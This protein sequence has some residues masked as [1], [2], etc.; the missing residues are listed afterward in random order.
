[1]KKKFLSL[2][3]VLVLCV[4][5]AISASAV[6]HPG[7]TVTRTSQLDAYLP[8]GTVTTYT[9]N[10]TVD[11][12]SDYSEDI[13]ITKE[14]LHMSFNFN[15]G[16][17]IDT[18]KS[19]ETIICPMIDLEESI[20]FEHI[21]YDGEIFDGLSLSV[22]MLENGNSWDVIYKLEQVKNLPDNL[23][24]NFTILNS[25]DRLY[26]LGG[27]NDLTT[28]PTDNGFDIFDS[29]YVDFSCYLDLGSNDNISTLTFMSSKDGGTANYDAIKDFVGFDF[30][31][32]K[33][34]I[35]DNIIQM[36]DCV[37]LE[38]GAWYENAIIYC[39][40][41]GYVKGYGD[42]RFGP[43]DGITFA[44][45]A[46]ILASC[47]ASE[48][49]EYYQYNVDHWAKD[50]IG[51]AVRNNIFIQSDV[52]TNGKPDISKW[53]KPMTREQAVYSIVQYVKFAD[54]DMPNNAANIP[55]IDSVDVQYRDGVKLAYQYGITNGIDAKGTFSPK[56]PVTRAEICQMIYSNRL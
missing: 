3:L 38:K 49:Y 32:N 15:Y 16:G 42:G 54:L 52:L 33:K 24:L 34:L 55:D 6:D 11:Y 31:S 13:T 4:V 35:D 14:Y 39:S 48:M 37:D 25:A 56:S 50:A 30:S 1:M 9:T 8:P 12:H 5:L 21:R 26:E 36:H 27:S 20:D 40:A 28:A 22:L 51:F 53:D 10:I 47:R 41:A 46:T 7:N 43:N 29:D 18:S 23:N 44:Q 45:L 19:D 2:T 17:I